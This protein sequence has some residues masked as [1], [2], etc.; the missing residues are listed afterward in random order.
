MTN[1]NSMASRMASITKLSKYGPNH[2][3]NPTFF[4]SVVG[5]L[6]YA[7]VTRPEEF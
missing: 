5:G 6:Q 3:S 7:T 4:R 1:A 2:V